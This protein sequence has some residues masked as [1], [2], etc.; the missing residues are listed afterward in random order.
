M[1]ERNKKAAGRTALSPGWLLHGLAAPR[2]GCSTGWLL[3]GL[4]VPGHST[5]RLKLPG[6]KLI[7][8]LPRGISRHLL[9]CL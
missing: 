8:A 4:A 9:E 5:R 6:L 1:L 3:H 7:S 2:A